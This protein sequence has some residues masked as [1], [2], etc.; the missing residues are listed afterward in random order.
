L[1]QD[2]LGGACDIAREID[3]NPGGTGHVGGIERVATLQQQIAH[4]FFMRHLGATAVHIIGHDLGQ[5]ARGLLVETEEADRLADG[6]VLEI[7]H[8]LLAQFHGHAVLQAQLDGLVARLEVTVDQQTVGGLA[9]DQRV[10]DALVVEHVRIHQQHIAA[11]RHGVRHGMHGQHA[12]EVET[13]IDHDLGTLG[14]PEAID[15]GFHLLWLEAER[16]HDVL[17]AR[18]IQHAHMPLEQRGSVEAQ[19]ALGELCPR[20]LLQAQAKARGKN[21]CSHCC[22]TRQAIEIKSAVVAGDAMRPAPTGRPS[23]GSFQRRAPALEL[24]FTQMQI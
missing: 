1:G 12:A 20:L 3:F 16:E 22:I 21:D 13:F 19:Q 10:E 11:A 4:R 17:H 5:T 15:L 8:Q 23:F 2:F 9:R 18:C 6:V 14:Q 7:G 24:P